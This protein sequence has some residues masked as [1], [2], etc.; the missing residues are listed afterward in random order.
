MLIFFLAICIFLLINRGKYTEDDIYNIAYNK[1]TLFLNIYNNDMSFDKIQDITGI[2]TLSPYFTV[3]GLPMDKE[4]Y[5][6]LE[7]ELKLEGDS[8]TLLIL[9][10]KTRLYTISSSKDLMFRLIFDLPGFSIKDVTEEDI[11]NPSNWRL[12]WRDIK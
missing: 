7:A 10:A 9:T 2:S 6:I 5:K 8:L 12:I 11:N 1:L 3:E 4:N